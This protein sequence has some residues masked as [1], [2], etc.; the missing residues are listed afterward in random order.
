M[1]APVHDDPP[2]VKPT[3]Q[4]PCSHPADKLVQMGQQVCDPDLVTVCTMCGLAFP[5]QTVNDLLVA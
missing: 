5:G 4:A 3:G 1:T 2:F